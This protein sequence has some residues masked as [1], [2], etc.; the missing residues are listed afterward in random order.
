M[1]VLTTCLFAGAVSRDGWIDSQQYLGHAAL[2]IECI[3]SNT[4]PPAR[5][6]ARTLCLL[7]CLPLKSPNHGSSCAISPPPV[8]PLASPV[9]PPRRCLHPPVSVS[10]CDTLC[11]RASRRPCL[12]CTRRPLR[13]TVSAR[14][15]ETGQT[16]AHVAEATAA[17]PAPPLPAARV[18]C[19]S[20]T[21]RQWLQFMAGPCFAERQP[22]PAA[23][24]P[25]EAASLP[26]RR[27]S[28]IPITPSSPCPCLAQMPSQS[29]P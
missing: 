9:V 28:K 3:F 11:A 27:T 5:P 8:S 14:P 13:A 7:T 1:Y 16:E 12:R 2:L 22:A 25:R 17:T 24:M 6:H 29:M 15:A 18:D 23:P 21:Q 19:R 20:V 10:S 26:S 4:A